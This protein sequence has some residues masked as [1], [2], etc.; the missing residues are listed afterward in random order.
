MAGVEGPTEL[1]WQFQKLFVNTAAALKY[2]EKEH[3][4]DVKYL[5]GK[6]L[7]HENIAII[8]PVSTI[9]IITIISAQIQQKVNLE[10]DINLFKATKTYFK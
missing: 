1:W 10:I 6:G 3:N 4:F 7:K 5:V 8:N 9:S 2:E